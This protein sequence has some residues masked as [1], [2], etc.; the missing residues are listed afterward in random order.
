MSGTTSPAAST[1]TPNNLVSPESRAR[2]CAPRQASP[3]PQD[4]H[5]ALS[6][7]SSSQH[8]LDSSCLK[9]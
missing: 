5:A 8:I 3:R 7:L 2:P 6:V 1:L 4:T 9:Q